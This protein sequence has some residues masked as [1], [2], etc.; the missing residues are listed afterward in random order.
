[1]SLILTS[2]SHF[3]VTLPDGASPYLQKVYEP[4]S[5]LM[6]VTVKLK[7]SDG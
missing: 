7:A 5:S 4:L 3:G 1:V 6:Q 2:D